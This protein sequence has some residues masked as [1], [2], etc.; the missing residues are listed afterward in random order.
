VA[1][2]AT[3]TARQP[4][5]RGRLAFHPLRVA[6]VDR[7]TEDAVAVTFAVPPELREEFDFRAGQH[8]TVRRDIDGVDVRRSY[9]ICAPAGSSVLRI[10]IKLIPEGAFSTHAN[11]ALAVG[12]VVDVLTPLGHFTSDF[13]PDRKRWYGLVAAGSGI[14][15]V[16]S[17]A[18]TALAVEPASRVTLLYG[19]RTTRSVMFLEEL[20]DLK[21]RYP[22]RFH[23]V[24]VLSGEPGDVELFS[25]R[26]D[27]G[28][29][30]RLVD[31]LGMPA[32]V[33]EW[34]LCGPYG[35]V[36]GAQ[37][38]LLERGVPIDRVHTELFHVEPAP[39]PRQIVRVADGRPADT[40]EVSVRLDGRTTTVRMDRDG[41]SVLD[42]AMAARTDLPYACKG[43]VCS[44][45]RA[46]VL[47]GEVR[48]AT[49]YALEPADVERGYVLTCQSRPVTERVVLDFDA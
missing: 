23:L 11:T 24:H 19:N 8:V 41:P 45:C 43:G 4:L 39:P 26:L 49:N 6:A 34:F 31:L 38:V 47:D 15:P 17:I 7:L 12:D 30:A 35:M 20:A 37:Q 28:R 48:M 21:D 46:K 16:L 5:R 33:D 44:T 25:G 36:T 42:A 14:T 40:S 18:A 22:D 10:G 9:S 1:A 27:A 32:S 29:F 3:T 13:A 2:P